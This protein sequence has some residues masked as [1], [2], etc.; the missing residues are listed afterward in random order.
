MV[1]ARLPARSRPRLT[2]AAC[3]AAA[4]HGL[5]FAGL[6]LAG[7][8]LLLVVAASA[9]LVALGAGVFIPSDD[10]N[11]RVLAVLAYLEG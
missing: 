7:L 6:M 2:P 4:F 8:G 1:T 9:F 10:D 5:A 11:R 3:V